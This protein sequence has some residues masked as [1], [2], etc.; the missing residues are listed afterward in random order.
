MTNEPNTAE[1]VWFGLVALG[2]LISSGG[3]V[4]TSV[5]LALAGL[6]LA[7]AGLLFFR[8]RKED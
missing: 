7:G 4:V 5:S 3:V 2:F 8:L 1:F 6:A